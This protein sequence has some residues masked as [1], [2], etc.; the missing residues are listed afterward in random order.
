MAKALQESVDNGTSKLYAENIAK[1]NKEL[2]NSEDKDEQFMSNY[3]FSEENVKRF[4]TF[5]EEC[6]GFQVC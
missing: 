3:P 1:Q 6:G 5:L 2:E 4:I